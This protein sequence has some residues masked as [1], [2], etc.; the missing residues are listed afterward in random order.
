MSLNRFQQ[1]FIQDFP[2]D[3]TL[4]T[5]QRQTPDVLSALVKP[6]HFLKAELIT[7]N[8]DFLKNFAVE[9][10]VNKEFESFLNADVPEE[11]PT[12][13]TAYAGH[14]FGNWAG[15][16]GD[17]R[18]IFAG[19]IRD[20]A[21]NPWEFQWKGAGAT[22]YSRRGDGRAVLR[23][24]IREYLMSEAMYHL[25]IPTT[26]SVSLSVTGEDVMRDIMYNG[27][28]KFEKGALMIRAA[29][30]FL[31]FGHFEFLTANGK[32]DLLKKLADLTIERYF[33]E[34]QALGKEKY[35]EFFKT[36]R[37]KT[38]SLMVEWYRVG[39]VHGVMNTDNM[40][41]LGLTMDY[42]PY[43]MMEEYDLGFTSNTTDLPG[44]RYAFG[45][46]GNIALWNLNALANALFP[47]LGEAEPLEEILNGFERIFWNEFD[48]MMMRKFGIENFDPESDKEFLNG[49][50]K[51]MIALKPDYTL[52]FTELI[53]FRNSD[54]DFNPENFLYKSI[55]AKEEK[56]LNEFL[57]SYSVRLEL[58]SISE[59]ESLELM[60]KTNPQFILRNFQLYKAAQEAEHGNFDLFFQLNDALKFPYKNRLPELI[61]KRPNWAEGVAGCSMLSCSS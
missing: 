8:E 57:K 18:A 22:P 7:L 16:L 35:L 40:S 55:Y 29:E 53:K 52:F 58:N 19:E 27:N 32:T 50:Q 17:G 28:P 31:R 49:W 11:M 20:K 10:P 41:V 39:F 3:T 48:G 24:T 51:M 37:N 12:Y 26:R 46:Q 33:P 5:V 23:S 54:K 6:V 9:L 42:G 13:A 60:K 34:I 14:Q 38:V 2:C 59:M 4:N 21:G 43:A 45:R 30:S 47:L 36:V 1:P 56:L 44:R 15:Q 61:C 25:G